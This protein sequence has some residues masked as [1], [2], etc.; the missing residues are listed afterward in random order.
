MRIN[1][2]LAH[3]T[4]LSRRKADE[5]I[6]AGLVMI[7]GQIAHLG[8]TVKETD[9]VSI[10]GSPVHTHASTTLVMLHKPEGYV[11]SRRGQGSKTIYELLPPEYY[12]LNPVGRLDKDSSGLLLLTDDGE[13]LNE[14]SHPSNSHTK[15]YIVTIDMPLNHEDEVLLTR[16]IDIGDNRPSRLQLRLLDT[17]RLVWQVKISEGRNRQIRRSFATVERRVMSL[18]RTH[19]GQYSLADLE[20]GKLSVLVV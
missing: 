16:G 10:D 18:H 19:F 13:L 9:N 6:S 8:S 15:S 11:C 17:K 5:V 20:T 3:H 14:L 7:N 2:F 1:K 12:R 4:H